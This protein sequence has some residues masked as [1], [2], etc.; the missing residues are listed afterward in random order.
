L[1]LPPQG[2]LV[3]ISAPSGTGKST[4]CKR[5]RADN[6]D[7]AVSISYTTRSPRGQEVDGKDYHF[8][9]DATFDR[10]IAEGRFLEWA[11]VHSKRYG[12]G[13][14]DVQSLLDQGKDVLFDIDVQG[15]LQIIDAVTD[16]V[17]VFLLPP[18]IEE[19][20][21]RLQD[22]RTESA[23]Q[24]SKR[25]RTAV[26]ELEQGWKYSHHVINDSLDEAVARVDTI[27][28][29]PHTTRMQCTTLLEKL[30]RDARNY[31]A[32]LT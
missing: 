24:M 17:L 32:Q 27:R 30:I 5:L 3:V 8:V 10:M 20:A 7:V 14:Q 1:G 18:S 19:L 4:I 2:K 11:Q 12:S 6:P 26:W 22:R 29:D 25:M 21:R 9:D 15:G 31:T 28:K 23:E 16:A 13:K